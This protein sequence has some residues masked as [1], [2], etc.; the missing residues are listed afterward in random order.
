MTPWILIRA[1]LK[2]PLWKGLHSHCFRNAVGVLLEDF[3][4]AWHNFAFNEQ[5]QPHGQCIYLGHI[6]RKRSPWLSWRC[7]NSIT[8]SKVVTQINESNSPSTVVR[9]KQPGILN[10]MDEFWIIDWLAVDPPLNS[11]WV[12]HFYWPWVNTVTQNN[13]QLKAKK[14][15]KPP[16]PSGHYVQVW[17]RQDKK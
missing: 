2:A 3:F 5:A 10:S 7:D 4:R 15:R 1:N 16:K 13:L 6:S 9:S 14:K 12:A 8:D 17:F 11:H